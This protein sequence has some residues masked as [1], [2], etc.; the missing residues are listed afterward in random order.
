MHEPCEISTDGKTFC[1]VVELLSFLGQKWIALIVRVMYEGQE[2]FT[3]IK[4][5]LPNISANLLTQR[6]GILIEAGYVAKEVVVIH[7]L[8]IKYILTPRG[9]ELGQKIDELSIRARKQTP[10][11]K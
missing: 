10:L 3:G 5:A 4:N 11:K 8:K 9:R 2:T 1:P 6:M 7:P